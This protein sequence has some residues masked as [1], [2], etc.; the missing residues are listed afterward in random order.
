MTTREML[1]KVADDLEGTA[2]YLE[3]LIAPSAEG[4]RRFEARA[5][6][7]REHVSQL[8]TLADRLDVEM[9]TYAHDANRQAH[10][11]LARLDAPLV[12]GKCGAVWHRD[13]H[14]GEERG[15]CKRPAGHAGNHVTSAGTEW[16]PSGL[17]VV[18]APLG[19][20]KT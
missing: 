20:P 16:E 15:H 4:R 6:V 13:S 18:D 1:R 2:A 3:S 7:S 8:R 19:E 12:D 5:R 14:T 17:T 10:N 11:L 9:V